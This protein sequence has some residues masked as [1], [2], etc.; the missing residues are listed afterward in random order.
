MH[1]VEMF[2]ERVFARAPVI[3]HVARK[4]LQLV[5]HRL[6]VTLEIPLLGRLEVAQLAREVL[7]LAV[8]GLDVRRHVVVG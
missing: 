4:V 7:D 8:H 1:V 6:F 3:T 5:V 2:H